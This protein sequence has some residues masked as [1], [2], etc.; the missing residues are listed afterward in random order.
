[1]LTLTNAY[2]FDPDPYYKNG[3]RIAF[4]RHAVDIEPWSIQ[5]NPEYIG[6]S[7]HRPLRA[8]MRFQEVIGDRRYERL[9]EHLSGFLSRRWDPNS[10]LILDAHG[11]RPN[12]YNLTGLYLV[13]SFLEAYRITG[14]ESYR[15]KAEQHMR[16]AFQLTSAPTGKEISMYLQF[17]SWI[18]FFLEMAGIDEIDDSPLPDQ[19]IKGREEGVSRWNGTPF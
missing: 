5:P 9:Y 7:S 1:L 3:A 19:V 16:A 13:E 2:A 17:A 6:S 4:D 11:L 12:R 14:D 15:D 8:L 18:P 10:W